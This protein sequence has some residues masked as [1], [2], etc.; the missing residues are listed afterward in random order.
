MRV[1]GWSLVVLLFA[2]VHPAAA[3][4]VPVEPN[5]LILPAPLEREARQ[6]ERM[7]IAPCCWMQP[8]SEH[9][10]EASEKVKLEIRERLGRGMNRQQILDSFVDEYSVRILAEPPNR[11]FSRFLYLTPWLVF[12]VSAFGLVVL[13]KKMTAG[14]SGAGAGAE[15]GGTASPAPPTLAADRPG[16]SYEQQLDD[17][18]RDLD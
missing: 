4:Q 14:R 5:Q 16:A 6:I 12:G 11:G 8:V 1:L 18:L 17:E 7:L 15:A 3:R 13:V 2:A 9:A 10:S